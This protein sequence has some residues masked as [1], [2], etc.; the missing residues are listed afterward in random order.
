MDRIITIKAG[1]IEVEATLN[2]SSTADAVWK[3]LPLAAR[4]NTWGDEIYFTI[5]V[6]KE[7]EEGREV[8]ELGDLGYWPPGHAFCIFF[9]ATPMSRGKEIRPASAVSVFGKVTGDTTK[10][11]QVK[12]GAQITIDKKTG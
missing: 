10:L 4:A 7:L 9:G 5:P 1:S 3:A 12:S 8:V 2:S 6:R 11:K